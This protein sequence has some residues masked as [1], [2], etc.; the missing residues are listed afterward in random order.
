MNIHAIGTSLILMLAAGFL[1]S[2]AAPQNGPGN[3]TEASAVVR[4]QAI[5][6]DQG[7]CLT[8][9][10]VANHGSL[11]GT[12]LTEI[13]LKMTPLQLRD[14]LIHPRPEVQGQNQLYSVV[15]RDG[16]GYT[17]KLL[18][19]D[20]FSLQMLDA[21]GRLISFKKDGLRASH[22]TDTAP[23]P[24]YKEKLSDRQLDDLIAFLTSLKGVTPQ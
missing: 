7:K 13:G 22:L 11:V 2:P 10:L 1:V 15:T 18:N 17:G 3:T 4:G 19:Q 8:C 5:F 12:D 24:S 21:T 23:M 20:D 16:T 6:E 14:A 9:H